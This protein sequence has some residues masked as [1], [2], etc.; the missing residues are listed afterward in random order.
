MPIHAI[1]P[2]E[3][4]QPTGSWRKSDRIAFVF[5]VG[6][7]LTAAWL[8]CRH[9]IPALGP[10]G[11]DESIHALYGLIIADDLR[12]L[13]WVGLL[14]DTYRQVY[15]PP[16]HSW[17]SGVVFLFAGPTDLTARA[18]SAACLAVT[19]PLLYLTARRLSPRHGV[20]AGLLAAWLAITSP[21][22]LRYS[23]FCLLEMPGVT[24]VALTL[25]LWTHL[26]TRQSSARWYMLV[27]LGILA[28]FFSKTNYGILLGLALVVSEI[29]GSRAG[30]RNLLTRRYFYI[31]LPV[32]TALALWFAYPAKLRETWELLVNHPWGVQE[33]YGVEGLLYFPRAFVALSGSAW[34][35]VAFAVCVLAGCWRW[36]D[37]RVRLLVVLVAL[38]FVIGELHHT[39]LSRHLLPVYP[40][41]FVLAGLAGAV[42]W[43]GLL[44]SSTGIRLWAGRLVVIAAAIHSATLPWHISPWTVTRSYRDLAREVA[45]VIKPPGKGLA[46]IPWDVCSPCVEW[47][48]ASE[49]A[50]MAPQQASAAA[51]RTQATKLAGA[52]RH[53]RGPRFVANMLLPTLERYTGEGELPVVLRGDKITPTLVAELS[54]RGDLDRLAILHLA[55]DSTS[56]QESPLAPSLLKRVA[57]H[58]MNLSVNGPFSDS[59]RTL[60]ARLD[61]YKK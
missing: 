61:I 39:K 53:W 12:R 2:A 59:L 16:L 22:L 52:L 32:V 13:D 36:R 58:P 57:S 40:A 20:T 3:H 31:G 14:Y 26:T 41:V 50:A 49:H 56:Q 11:W 24:S 27:G 29:C 5:V 45:P 54:N 9:L 44:A 25:F 4:S 33:S 18:T 46:V 15:W 30:F 38:Q 48:L 6:A 42:C 28:A 19:P 37:P 7:S 1:M 43:H 51:Q 10:L 34:F 35:A 55:P 23:P 21:A 47:L 60:N 17:L 8:V